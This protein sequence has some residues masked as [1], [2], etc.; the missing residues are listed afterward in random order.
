MQKNRSSKTASD[1]WTIGD[2]LRWG[3]AYFADQ[4]ESHPQR[5]I[6]QLLSIALDMPRLELYLN[7]DKPL[8][9]QE[10]QTLRRLIHRYQRGTPLPYLAEKV[11]FYGLELHIAPSALIP[12]PESELLVDF[13][14]YAAPLFRHPPSILDIGTGSGCLAIAIKKF[15]PHAMVT[16]IDI[17]ADALDLAERNA[18]RHQCNIQWAQLDILSHLPPNA[19]FDIIVSNPPYISETEFAS[20]PRS[21]RDYEPR[22]ALIAS[23]EGLQFYYRFAEIFSSVLS[24]GGFF[25]VEIAPTIAA[26]IP[27]IF[28]SWHIAIFEDFQ[29]HP[30]IL[31]GT[32]TEDQLRTLLAALPGYYRRWEPNT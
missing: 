19:P 28:A 30:R 23:A 15:L 2:L 22:Q 10:R 4:G 27:P 11:E 29:H 20:L 21:V 6:E 26:R 25:F 13:T 5:T 17:S 9:S 12:R 7:F 24:S 1:V 18:H 16:A 32:D 8:S 31:A 14:R 3:T